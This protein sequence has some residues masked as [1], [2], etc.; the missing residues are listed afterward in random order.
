MRQV[1]LKKLGHDDELDALDDYIKTHGRRLSPKGRH[2]AV[3]RAIRPL[4]D[5]LVSLQWIPD[6]VGSS[7]RSVHHLKVHF[8]RIF[9]TSSTFRD[10][11]HPSPLES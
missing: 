9:G 10:A 7:G 4:V 5:S 11:H 2:L 1:V 6:A 3:G 8:A